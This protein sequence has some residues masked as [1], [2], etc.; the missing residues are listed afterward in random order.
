MHLLEAG[1]KY[2]C[3]FHCHSNHS[4]GKLSRKQVI[5]NAIEQNPGAIPIM[6]LTDHNVSFHDM[7]ELQEEF[8]GQ[9]LLISGSEI[10]TTYHVPGSTRKVEVHIIALDYQLDHPKMLAM[11]KNNIHDKR[12]DI[13]LI[14]A[15]LENL[16]FH[17]VD[18]YEELE[19]YVKPSKHVGRMAIARKMFEKEMVESI[20]AAFDKYFGSY[21]ERRCYVDSQVD[22]V[23]I[24]EAVQTTLEAGGIP[25]LCHPYFYSLEDHQLRELI[26]VFKA[27]GGLAMEV[28]YGFYT[29]EQRVAL[30]ELAEEYELEISCGSDYHGNAH[31]RLDHQ[32]P[33]KIYEGLMALK[34]KL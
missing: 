31:E 29:P 26:R 15:K 24:E 25:V 21:G 14:L 10:S 17:V 7:E 8:Q 9:A 11:L 5:L 27:A 3:D 28:E 30:K 16:G 1:K 23:S 13:E 19:E 6:A 34:E 32:F 12:G 18:S 20:D 4:D 22:Y 33:V 2:V